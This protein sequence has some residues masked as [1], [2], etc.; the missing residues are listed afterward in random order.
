MAVVSTGSHGRSAGPVAAERRSPIVLDLAETEESARPQW[1]VLQT[2]ARQ[3]KAIAR[4]FE[5][6]GIEHYLPLMNRVSYRGSRRSIVAEPLFSSYLFVF[7]TLETA[8]FAV[9]TKRVANVIHVSN[10]CE[11]RN[12]LIHLRSA[13][14]GGAEL[15][16]FRYLTAGRRARVRSGPF[17]DVEGLIETDPDRGRLI[18]Q[19]AALGRATSLEIDASLLEPLD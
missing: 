18:L 3:E 10:Q 11:F 14:D 8:Y 16:P 19:V 12:E 2:R 9:S 17:R 7:G 13:L 4:T 6:A 1:R 5:A 15:Y